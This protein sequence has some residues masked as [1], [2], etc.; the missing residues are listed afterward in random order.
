LPAPTALGGLDRWILARLHAV[1]GECRDAYERFDAAAVTRTVEGFW[2]DLSTWYVRRGRRRYWKATSEADQHAAYRTLYEGLPTTI[3][4]VAPILPFTS[5]HLH[6]RLIR[7]VHPDAPESV[8]LTSFPRPDA[9]WADARLL[10]DVE[11]VLRVVR[12]GRAA[13]EAKELKV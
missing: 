3:R 6:Q 12:L 8:H 2:D 5:E 4:L 11:T 13:R 7:P 10:G 9:A 1:V